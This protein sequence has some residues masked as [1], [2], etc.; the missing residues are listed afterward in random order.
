MSE[1]DPKAAAYRQGLPEDTSGKPIDNAFFEKY[2]QAAAA[3]HGLPEDASEDQ[4]FAATLKKID[5]IIGQ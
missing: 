1:E 2:G 5:D 4:I 3:R